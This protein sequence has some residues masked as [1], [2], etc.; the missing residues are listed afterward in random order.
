MNPTLEK[1]LIELIKAVASEE[2]IN[3]AKADLIAFLGGLAG[4]TSTQL[5]DEIVKIL[6]A[7]LGVTYP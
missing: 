7:A 5:D 3:A 2:H 6:A 1:I 4:G